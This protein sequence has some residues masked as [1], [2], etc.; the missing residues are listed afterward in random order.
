V[1]KCEKT[2][3]QDIMCERDVGVEL[4][5]QNF[6]RFW[7][8]VLSTRHL[9]SY[10]IYSSTYSK[11]VKRRVCNPASSATRNHRAQQLNST[12]EGLDGATNV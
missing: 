10:F 6:S 8:V 11:I 9:L 3:A 2:M 4:F 5:D 12:R 7:L 1:R